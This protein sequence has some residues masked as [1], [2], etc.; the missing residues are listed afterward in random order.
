MGE[1][2]ISKEERFMTKRSKSL[3]VIFSIV[4]VAGLIYL[5][6]GHVIDVGVYSTP[7]S[8]LFAIMFLNLSINFWGSISHR[9]HKPNPKKQDLLNALTVA[10]IVPVYNEDPKL[11]AAGLDSLLHQTRMPQ[12]V[13]ITD[14]GSTNQPLRTWPVRKAVDALRKGGVMVRTKRQTNAGKR[15][16]QAAGFTMSKADIYVTIDSDTVLDP[17]AIEE[18]LIPFQQRSTMSVAGI[19]YGQN[20]KKSLLT[21]IIELGFSNSFMSGRAAEGFF[22]TVRVNCGIIAA[23]RGEIVRSNMD[24]YLSQTFLGA[25]A[26]FGDDRALTILSREEGD[27]LY[28]PT[29]IAYSALPEKINHLIRQRLRWAKSWF[30]GTWWLLSRPFSS[31]EFWLTFFQICSMTAY[32]T[33]VG[34]IIFLASTGAVSPVIVGMTMLVSV[35]IGMV[36]NLRY[37]FWGRRDVSAW[38]RIL[39]W[40]TSPLSSVLYMVCLTPLYLV[41]V[42]TLKKNGWGTRQKVEVELDVSGAKV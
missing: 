41:A 6:V 40:L 4:G 34:S 38:D 17:K 10:V 14:D 11:L 5:G 18:L 36:S 30:W 24:R 29:A 3:S 16:A 32:F 19:V 9:A 13:W 42:L 39:T 23:Y 31:P 2:C 33:A 1:N 25:P 7:L 27:C 12:E 21:R 26:L 37:I 8:V 20:H 15:H 35:L 22:K 28:Q